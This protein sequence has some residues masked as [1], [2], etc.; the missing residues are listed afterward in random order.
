MKKSSEHGA[1]KESC[2]KERSEKWYNH[3]NDP[4]GR[5]PVL[6]KD[7]NDDLLTICPWFSFIF[8]AILNVLLEELVFTINNLLVYF[9]LD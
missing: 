7:T 9:A 8:K 4:L 2:K 6:E 1:I 3:F 5:V